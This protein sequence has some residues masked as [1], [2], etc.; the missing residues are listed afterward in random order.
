MFVYHV[1]IICIFSSYFFSF[2]PLQCFF[3]ISAVLFFSSSM[4]I[5]LFIKIRFNN[6]NSTIICRDCKIIF[7]IFIFH[8]W[9]LVAYINLNSCI[10]NGRIWNALCYG[11]SF[12]VPYFS[13]DFND[14]RRSS[15]RSVYFNF[16]LMVF[17]N[18][19]ISYL[20]SNPCITIIFLI[21]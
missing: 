14:E 3:F 20:K 11:I 2:P 17:E 10:W 5:L 16:H 7:F 1:I 6:Y 19:D 18:Y 21:I 15:W 8:F 4:M 12:L 13:N 9:S